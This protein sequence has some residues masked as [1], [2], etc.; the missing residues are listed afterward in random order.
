[1]FP[2]GSER[3]R[4]GGDDRID[5]VTRQGSR[6]KSAKSLQDFLA[7]KLGDVSEETLPFRR[8]T[9]RGTTL[10]LHLWPS[11]TRCIDLLALEK[12]ATR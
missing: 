10:L 1:M 2:M 11:R 9:V 8:Y 5:S 4:R 12:S 6:Q 3:D 7:E